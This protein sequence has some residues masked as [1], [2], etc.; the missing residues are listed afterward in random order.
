MITEK[1]KTVTVK[2]DRLLA[3]LKENR[4]KHKDLYLKAEEGYRR[5]V[6]EQLNNQL[7]LVKSGKPIRNYISFDPPEDHTS[8]YDTAIEMLEWSVSQEVQID[9]TEFQCYVLDKWPWFEVTLT[10]NTRY[11]NM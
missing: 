10:K 11:S 3:T 2:K 6:V 9:M 1:L 8:D 7:D 5:S 4:S